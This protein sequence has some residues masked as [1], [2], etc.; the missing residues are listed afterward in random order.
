[1]KR[2]LFALLIITAIVFGTWLIVIP[3]S[4]IIHQIENSLSKNNL[5][6]EITGF[7][8]GLFFSFTSQN[9][10]LK[11]SDN[12][13]LSLDNVVGK[14]NPLSLF[15]M[16]PPL[17]FHGDISGGKITGEV[18]LLRGKNHVNVNIDNANVDGIPLFRV[19]GL[20]G[21]GTLSGEF[22]LRKG[23]GNLKFSI[24]DAQF[25]STSFSGVIIPVNMFQIA[26]G[27]MTIDSNVVH[28]SSLSLQGDGI[29]ARVKGN[30][31][32]NVMDLTLE[33]MQDSS[34]AD[35]SSLLLFLENYKVSPGYY[36]IP[37]KGNVP[38]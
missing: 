4:L 19:M 5:Q 25:E 24:K 31:K 35:K 7:K 36:V 21:K 26:Q 1:M 37:I 34:S 29:Y 8:K 3:S 23:T 28:I 10:I 14:I 22:S 11:K 38:F 16:K 17:T 33:L 27:A 15:L 18:N 20:G 9:F 30:I 32:K 6:G 13:L 12:T 2:L